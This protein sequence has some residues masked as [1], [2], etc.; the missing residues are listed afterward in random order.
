[1]TSISGLLA[2]STGQKDEQAL[3][4]RS[5]ENAPA[6]GLSVNFAQ[7]L[8]N[9]GD[10]Q[11]TKEV[12]E[13]KRDPNKP[14]KASVVQE[15]LDYM[16]KSPA[17]RLRDQILG[18][19]GLTEEDVEAL[20]PEKRAALEEEIAQR[21]KDYLTESASGDIEEQAEARIAAIINETYSMLNK[22]A[23]AE[24]EALPLIG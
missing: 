14:A 15:F 7:M 3:L 23:E 24:D 16:A 21:I 12:L 19:K 6:S 20:P 5:A 22:P 13:Q 17:E 11:S 8:A 2:P 1:M 4:R 10:E 18:E 9:V